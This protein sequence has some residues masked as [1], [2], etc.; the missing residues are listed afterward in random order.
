[1]PNHGGGEPAG[2]AACA[3]LATAIIPDATSAPT[4][5]IRRKA[6]VAAAIVVPSRIRLA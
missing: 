5:M 2:G 4:V 6:R 1:L 3:S